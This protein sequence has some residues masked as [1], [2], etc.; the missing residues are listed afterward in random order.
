MDQKE[1]RKMRAIKESR[2]QP[3]LKSEEPQQK[4]SRRPAMLRI[5]TSLVGDELGATRALKP[6]PPFVEQGPYESEE[7]FLNRLTRLSTQAKAEAKLEEHFGLDFCPVT[8]QVMSTRSGEVVGRSKKQAKVEEDRAERRR[9]K[10]RERDA[11][12]RRR[13]KRGG[14]GDGSGSNADYSLHQDF[15]HLRDDVAFADVVSA[16]PAFA[17]GRRRR[18]TVRLE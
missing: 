8:P 17:K 16:P 4:R 1:P 12:R 6:L 14:G 10:R 7:Q 9:A 3:H 11:R 2:K 5:T 18:E 13:T 15:Q